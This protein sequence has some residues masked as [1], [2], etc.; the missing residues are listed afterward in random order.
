MIVKPSFGRMKPPRLLLP[1]AWPLLARVSAGCRY[2]FLH[3][4]LG[5]GKTIDPVH[6]VELGVQGRIKS[7]RLRW[8]KVTASRPSPSGTVTFTALTTRANGKTV[9]CDDLFADTGPKLVEWPEKVGAL[10]PRPG[11]IQLQPVD[12]SARQT[13]RSTQRPRH[14]LQ[15]LELQI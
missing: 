14:A 11:D 6:L 5:A 12:D 13:H 1:R 2:I 7:R 10:L 9:A 4:D 3:G 15:S 8:Q